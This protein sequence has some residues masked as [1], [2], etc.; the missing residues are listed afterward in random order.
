MKNKDGWISV[1]ERA[2]TAYVSVLGY[3]P[4]AEPLPMVHECYMNEWGMWQ[5]AQVYG[6]GRVT[7]WMP[8][9]EPPK[10]TEEDK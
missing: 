6:I 9:P 1:L 5:S 2:P 8:M 7:H 3:C 4:E 10:E